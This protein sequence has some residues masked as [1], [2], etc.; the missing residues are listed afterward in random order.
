MCGTVI[1][2]RIFLPH[3]EV[4]QDSDSGI[5]SELPFTLFLSAWYFAKRL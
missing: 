3:A 1:V 4:L 2:I 5:V